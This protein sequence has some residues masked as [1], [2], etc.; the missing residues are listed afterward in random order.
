MPK[1]LDTT[2]LMH[3]ISVFHIKCYFVKQLV[4]AAVVEWSGSL[5]KQKMH[6]QNYNL[7]K[8]FHIFGVVSF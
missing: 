4:T 7:Q 6:P 1:T 2:G 8:H 5:K 3:F